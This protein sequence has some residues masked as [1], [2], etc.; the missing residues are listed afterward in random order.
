MKRIVIYSLLIVAL[1]GLASGV[2]LANISNKEF[3]ADERLW[4]ERSKKIVAKFRE[5]PQHLTTHLCHPGIPPALIMAASLALRQGMINR[6]SLTPDS[7]LYFDEFTAC[8]TAI[9]LGS[10]LV[11]PLVFIACLYFL[12][13]WPALAASLLLAMDP[14]HVGLSQQAHLDSFMTV[15]VALTIFLYAL[16]IRLARFWPKVLAGISWGLCIATKPTA[17]VLPACF[18]MYK[19]MRRLLIPQASDSGERDLLNW[20]DIFAVLIGQVTLVLVFTR[21]WHREND[22]SQCHFTQSSIAPWFFQAGEFLQDR[23][24]LFAALLALI[25]CTIFVLRRNAVQLGSCWRRHVSITLA[26]FALLSLA[27]CFFPQVFANL[28]RLWSR[29]AGFSHA[30][31]EAYGHKDVAATQGYLQ[32]LFCSLP[33]LC[34]IGVLLS[35]PLSLREYRREGATERLMFLW[36]NTLAILCWILPLS[37]ASKQAF[38]YALPVLPCI[39]ILAGYGWVELFGINNSFFANRLRAATGLLSAPVIA[40]TAILVICQA[41]EVYSWS[42]H[43]INYFSFLGGGLRRAVERRDAFVFMG[44]REAVGFLMEEA[45]KS[46]RTLKIMTFGDKKLLAD[47]ANRMFGSSK[48]KMLSF[49]Y[50]PDYLADFVLVLASHRRFFASDAWSR[51]MLEQ[52]VFA[53]EFRKVRVVEIYSSPAP[54]YSKPRIFSAASGHRHTGHAQRVPDGKSLMVVA[55]PSK[56]R[57]GHIFFTEQLRMQA[58]NYRVSLPVMRLDDK[59]H[60]DIYPDSDKAVRLQLGRECVRDVPANDLALNQ[61]K[62]EVLD[63]SFSANGRHALEVYWPGTAPVAIGDI[64]IQKI[65]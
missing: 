15:L 39:Y 53:Y 32:R 64:S 59:E 45:L 55:N 10:A 40:A 6:F 23:G 11:A 46:K 57:K 19:G 3:Q 47:E 60:S 48:R 38:R 63:C 8:R 56:S 1:Y 42:P 25:L 49:G 51:V 4:V 43:Q 37:V 54:D 21:L 22:Y 29:T 62:P 28:A 16:A 30:V 5:R 61:F 24:F 44:Q 36:F 13:L 20:G 27:L 26:I 17:A 52:P 7:R 33:P 18:L 50:F 41:G 65:N 31:H 9:A 58:G 2:R 14:R 12:G 35:L 34:V